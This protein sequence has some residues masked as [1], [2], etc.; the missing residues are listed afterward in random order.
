MDMKI[1]N[2][3]II[4]YAVVI[5]L[6]VNLTALGVMVYNRWLNP[7]LTCPGAGFEQLKRELS[8]SRKQEEQLLENRSDFHSRI[9]AL[10]V[11]LQ[12]ERIN[13]VEALR[14]EES[15][16]GELMDIIKRINAYQV[17]AQEEVVAHLLEVKNI[18]KPEQQD[19]FFSIMLERFEMDF[20]P[21]ERRYLRLR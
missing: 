16:Y 6:V 10:Y 18:L 8:L 15:D 13:L 21:G 2:I 14:N 1:K 17:Q 5:L 20:E 11:Q 4:T 3:K 7:E 19:I 9:D 12:E